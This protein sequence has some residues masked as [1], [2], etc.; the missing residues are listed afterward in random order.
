MASAALPNHMRDIKQVTYF[1]GRVQANGMCLC[2]VLMLTRSFYKFAV[3]HDKG[4]IRF[5]LGAIKGVGHG[6]VKTIVSNRKEDGS[7]KS[8]FDLAK[9]IDLRASNKK[10]FENL[11]NAGGFDCFDM[12]HR[13]QYFSDEGDGVTFLE[14]TI[15]YANKYQENKNSAQVSLFGEASNIQFPEPE[16]PPCEAWGTMEKL[17][18][19]KEVVGIYISGHPLDDFKTEM[20]TFC[21]ATI[22]LFNDLNNYVNRE[23]TFG[24]VVTDVQHRISKQGKGWAL[25]TVEDYIDTHEFRIFGE[26]YLKFRHFLLK[27]SFIYVRTFIKE[28]WT[29][30]DTGKKSEPRVQFNNF[31]LL[32]DVMD[33]YAKK[34]SI[35]FNIHDI[36]EKRIKEI[37]ELLKLHKGNHKLNFVIYD[38]EEQI[39]LQMPSRKQKVRISQELLDELENHE[40]FYK[41]N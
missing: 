13:A 5:G 16:I 31:Q 7:Y 3:N 26:E 17:A 14:K 27:S 24:G 4:A 39:K 34:L 32:H 8:I 21:N 37:Q 25:F 12:T 28:G 22:S 38:N 30:R 19:E 2:S 18:R 6:A 10:A 15:R 23:L 35:Q 11:A 33:S 20:N 40:V 1:H 9:R 41:L 29:N 36:K